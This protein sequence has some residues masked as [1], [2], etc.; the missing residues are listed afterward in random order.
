MTMLRKL[1]AYQRQNQLDL[2]Q[3]EI[4]RDEWTLSSRP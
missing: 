4:G 1:A 3:P 2:A